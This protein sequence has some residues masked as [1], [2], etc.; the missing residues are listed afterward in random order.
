MVETEYDSHISINKNDKIKGCDYYFK[1]E[2]AIESCNLEIQSPIK[3]IEGKNIKKQNIKNINQ[4]ET[5]IF[6]SAVFIPSIY[7][8]WRSLYRTLESSNKITRLNALIG[9]DKDIYDSCL[10]TVSFVFSKN[11][12]STNIFYTGKK[13]EKTIL[14]PLEKDD[15]EFGLLDYLHTASKFFVLTPDIK[16]TDSISIEEYLRFIDFNIKILLDFN[17]KPIFVPIQIKLPQ[18]Q[19]RIILEHYKS[20]GY[21]NIWIN[22]DG[23]H[24]GGTYFARIRILMRLIDRVFGLGN[25]VLY[26]SNLKKEINPHIK[27]DFVP[28]SD[29]LSQFYCGDFIGVCKKAPIVLDTEE[30]EKK[31]ENLVAKGEFTSKEEYY[32]EQLYNK[33]RLFNPNDYYY[34]KIQSYPLDLSTDKTVLLNQDKNRLLNSL[35]LYREIEMTKAFVND[36]KDLTFY[37]KN[38]RALEK[39]DI[40]DKINASAIVNTDQ[41]ALHDFL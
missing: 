13:K 8:N 31:L 34:Y 37:L 9:F 27:D 6:E 11:P 10:T 24:L 38:K 32:K 29:V 26:Y 18:K 3:V 23:A 36:K 33:T 17:N 28:S 15:Y 1:K 22:F 20:Q 7:R 12:F 35:L 25:V 16:F 30:F 14:E 21:S 41:R 5:P 19:L 40:L 4:L 39:E 2:L